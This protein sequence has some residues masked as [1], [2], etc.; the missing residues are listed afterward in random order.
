[1]LEL[2]ALNEN[3]VQTVTVS[4]T[5]TEDDY[6]SL[7]PELEK[8]LKEHG[9]IRFY[10]KLQDFNGF[11]MEALWEDIKF[12]SKHQSMFGRTAIIGQ[13]KWE[14]WGTKFSS[15]FFDAEMKFFYEDQAEEAWKWVN[16]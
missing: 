16:S 12:D 8:L 2:G 5:L 11:E 13:N 7:L 1:M 9:T 15:L 10:I 4:G 3:N 6:T 14:K